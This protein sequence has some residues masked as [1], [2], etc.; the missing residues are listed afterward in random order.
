[1]SREDQVA[2]GN[3][4]TFFVVQDA[5]FVS[6]HKLPAEISQTEERVAQ[7]WF[8]LDDL[9]ERQWINPTFAALGPR[10]PCTREGD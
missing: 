8:S 1:M 3:S 6:I 2:D 9:V 7:F 5:E 10:S 4:I